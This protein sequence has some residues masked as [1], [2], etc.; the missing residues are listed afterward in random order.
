MTKTK[1]NWWR[2]YMMKQFWK[3]IVEI[4]TVT[5]EVY[6]AP[7]DVLRKNLFSSGESVQC[8][9]VYQHF[10]VKNDGTVILC[11]RDWFRI[12]PM[13]NLEKESAMDIFNGEKFNEI[14]KSMIEGVNYPTICK[15]CKGKRKPGR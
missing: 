9:R 1:E 12:Y 6:I 11:C 7:P 10:S 4:V 14:R 5:K 8:K 13:G 15:Y 2:I 3:R